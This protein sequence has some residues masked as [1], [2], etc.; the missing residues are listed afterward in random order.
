MIIILLF[1]MAGRYNYIILIDRINDLIIILVLKI[2]FSFL[3]SLCATPQTGGAAATIWC[4]AV[5]N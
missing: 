5:N 2:L 1:C 3:Y 4:G